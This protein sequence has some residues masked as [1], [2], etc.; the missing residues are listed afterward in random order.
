MNDPEVCE[1]EQESFSATESSQNSLIIKVLQSLILITIITTFF[2]IMLIMRNP[3]RPTIDHPSNKKLLSQIPTAGNDIFEIQSIREKIKF[4][5]TINT[6]IRNNLQFF[7]WWKG[8]SNGRTK[9]AVYDELEDNDFSHT[10]HKEILYWIPNE[11]PNKDFQQ[12]MRSLI[13]QLNAKFHD[14]MDPSMPSLECEL[15]GSIN[16]IIDRHTKGKIAQCR[17]FCRTAAMNLY[18]TPITISHLGHMP[19]YNMGIVMDRI[20]QLIAGQRLFITIVSNDDET[21]AGVVISNRG[22]NVGDMLT[23]KGQF[24]VGMVNMHHAPKVDT[25][26]RTM[27]LQIYEFDITR[28]QLTV[29]KVQKLIELKMSQKLQLGDREWEV[30]DKYEFNTKHKQMEYIEIS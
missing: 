30:V 3:V 19:G 8:T 18:N 11:D 9:V 4:K 12:F 10:E 24:R 20:K 28:L 13:H 7:I 14:N 27:G 25:I 15:L 26:F 6:K 22:Q 29:P 16:H 17:V 23:S 5:D 2:I 1:D 21:A